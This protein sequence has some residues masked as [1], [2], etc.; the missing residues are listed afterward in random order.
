VTA[1]TRVKGHAAKASPDNPECL[2]KSA[3]TGK[4]AVRKPGRV[5][6]DYEMIAN[7]LK[8]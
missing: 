5:D 8:R 3:K 4:T 1:P 7:R 6:Q 2:A